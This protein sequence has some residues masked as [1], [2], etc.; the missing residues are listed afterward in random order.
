MSEV[1]VKSVKKALDL[2]SLLA[3]D[4]ADRAGLPLTAMARALGMPAN[5]THNLLKT[6]VACGYAAQSGDGHYIAGPQCRSIGIANRLE[7]DRFKQQVREVMNRHTGALNEAMVFA[8]LRGGRRTVLARSQPDG[9][10]IRVDSK[11]DEAI[12][13]YRVPTGRILA[14]FAS[15]E[16]RQKIIAQYGGPEEPWPEHEADCGRIRQ[17]GECVMLAAG[18]SGVHGFAAAVRDSRGT[19]L[20][21]IGCHAPAFRCDRAGQ[22][23]I[24]AALQ[25]AARE[26]G[27]A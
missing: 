25:G 15:P 17:S 1:P 23:K 13:L 24:R 19:L 4:D 3:F 7:S 2:L 5:T 14:A 11:M 20:G 12:S 26:L 18:L 27:G 9:Q 8:F 22:K 6:M 10:A 21:A 16:D